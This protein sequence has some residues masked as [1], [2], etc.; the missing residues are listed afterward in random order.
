MVGTGGGKASMQNNQLVV[1]KWF[2]VNVIDKLFVFMTDT[3]PYKNS[4]SPYL[5]GDA[6]SNA[7]TTS[8]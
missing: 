6:I 2:L 4:L 1:W 3:F 5:E 7:A 8:V